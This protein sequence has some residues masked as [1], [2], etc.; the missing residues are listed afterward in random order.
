MTDGEGSGPPRSAGSLRKTGPLRG[1]ASRRIT[2]LTD[3]GLTD[4]Y[5][6]AM[7]GV[8]ATLAPQAPVVD[9]SHG[10]PAQDV[11]AGAFLLATSY[12]FFPAG[13][14][15]VAVV[16]PGVGSER[17]L[18]AAAFR[19]HYFVGPNNGLLAGVWQG[20]APDLVV[21][22]ENPDY[23]LPEVSS[24]F[25]GR[26]VMAPVAAHLAHGVALSEFGPVVPLQ[27]A[28]S[29]QSDV[30]PCPWPL[31][32]GSVGEVI[33]CDRYGNCIT[34][35]PASAL[36][37]DDGELQGHVEVGADTTIP[38]HSHYAAAR[39][40]QPLALVG[41][42]GFLEIAVRDGDARSQLPVQRGT[43]VRYHPAP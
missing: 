16:D 33:H 42:A 8:L 39:P 14:I 1:A 41:S 25:H 17:A 26:D 32:R 22:L 43:A 15:H 18:L 10:V 6:A 2:L 24:T 29:A 27:Q 20:S 19:D 28:D 13:T 9:L 11:A 4:T 21:R 7:K 34:N 23:F 35:L 3:F 36:H 37:F 38:C 31:P 30:V 5:V 40:G 12:H